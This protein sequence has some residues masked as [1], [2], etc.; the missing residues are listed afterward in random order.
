ML[1]FFLACLSSPLKISI[2]KF[3]LQLSKPS[4]SNSHILKRLDHRPVISL[5]WS[6][7]GDKLI[8]AAACDNTILVWDVELDRTSSLKRPGGVG[9]ILVKWSPT[10]EKLFSCSNSLVFR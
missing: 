2:D 8:S 1:K 5:A 9:N 6:P 4:L 10:G 3:V 7:K